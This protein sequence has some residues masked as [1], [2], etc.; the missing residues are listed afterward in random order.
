MRTVA[1]ALERLL[2]A[3]DRQEIRYMLGGSLASSIHGIQ[4]FT[5]NI[6]I[7]AAIGV[8][9][10]VAL[11]EDLGRDFYMDTEVPARDDPYSRVQLVRSE[12]K[13]IAFGEGITVECPVVTAED[14]I[15]A[16]LAWYR[17]GGEQSDQ[18]WND[19]RG[20]GSVQGNRLD[21]SYLDTWAE[22][23]RVDDLLQRLLNEETP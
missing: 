19:L 17:L 10:T 20:V 23:L 12:V 22:T 9:H 14:T 4:R 5:R 3:L 18:Q 8:E 6:D 1:E 7:V 21:R 2:G 15:L 16:K 11:A 13:P